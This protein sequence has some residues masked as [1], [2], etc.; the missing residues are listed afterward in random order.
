M[1]N[2]FVHL[3]VHTQYS[4]LD[5]AGRVS[6]LI[7]TAKEKNMS[8]LAI[9]DHGVMYGVVDFYKEAKDQ[10]IKPILGC[11]VYVAERTRHDRDY[12]LDNKQYH[13]VLLAENNE[14][15]KNL[16]KLVSLSFLEGFYY[17]PRVDMELLQKYNEGLIA[18]SACLGG[19]LPAYILEGRYDKARE[20]AL[21]YQNIFGKDNFFLELQDHNIPEEKQVNAD[22]IALS[23]EIGAGI[24]ATND[25]HYTKKEDASIHDVLLCIQTGKELE[26]EDRLKFPGEEFYLKSPEEIEEIFGK[27]PEAL[28][29]TVEIANRCEVEIDLG[30]L[31][32]PVFEVPWGYDSNSYLRKLCYEGLKKRYQEITAEIEERLNYELDVIEEMGYSSYF[33]IVWDFV[34]F[35]HENNI[36]VGPGRGS[37]AGSLVAYTLEITNIDPLKY[38]LLFERFLNPARVNMP[39]IDIDFCYEKREKVIDYV[40]EKYGSEHVAQIITF[41][42][43]Q[44]RAA[45]RDVGRVLGY[46]YG[47][48]DKIAKMIPHVIGMTIERA[49]EENKELKELYDK[50]AN[51][52]NMLDLSMSIEGLYRHA[53]THAA[54]IVI[55]KEPLTEYVPLQ[56][57]NGQVVTQFPMGTLEE[58]GLLKMDFLGLKTLT[59]LNNAVNIISNISGTHIDLNEISFEDEKTFELLKEGNTLGIFQLESS[60]MRNV[61]KE[62]KPT[63]FEDIIAASALFRPGPME[64]I[65]NF[66]KSKHGKQ[67]IE[68]PHP[69][70][71]PILEETYGI[72]VYQEQIMQVANVMAGFS[73]GEADLLRRA[74]GKKKKEILAEQRVKF[75]EGCVQNGYDRELGEKIYE[76]IVKFADYG[77]NK[78]HSAAYACLAYQSAYLK[79][80]YP[81]E[82]MAALLTNSMDNS[83]KISL[84]IEDLKEQG[85]EILP[86]NINESLVNFTVVETGKIRFGLAAVKNVGRA[87]VEEIIKIRKEGGSFKSFLDFAN[88]VNLRVC[89]RKA[90]ESLIKVGAFDNFDVNRKQLLSVLDE[91]L[92][93]ASV[94]NREREKGQLS[95]WDLVEE[96]APGIEVEYPKLDEFTLKER[97]SMEREL[98]G[99][100]V[101]GHPLE[102]YREKINELSLP[103]I[104]TLEQ[105][106]DNALLSVCGIK[107]SINVITTKRGEFM[108]FLTLEDMTGTVEVVVFPP[109]YEA[110]KEFI[111]DDQPLFVKGTLDKKEDEEMKLICKDIR[112][113]EDVDINYA[114]KKNIE[115]SN[116][117]EE[118]KVIYIKVESEKYPYMNKLKNLLK[119]EK[120]ELPVYIYL[121]E[122]KKVKKVGTNYWASVNPSFI[123][124]IKK[125][126]GA[127]AIKIK[128]LNK[129]T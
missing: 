26:D 28:N 61:L 98:L 34:R 57:N 93:Q 89:N 16:M 46:S 126:L 110:S 73:L 36:L 84:Y 106:H 115:D 14:G 3:H 41:G 30:S 12:E 39:D 40:I 124:S 82:F 58:L 29:N 72:M 32:L 86:P 116:E 69:R 66:I 78:S 22:L 44:A 94:L 117:A 38:G 71:K 123:N 120:S 105:Y 129:K 2:N 5:G 1:M 122:E 125:I 95:M 42:T 55:S 91:V 31:H 68:Y 24:V 101:S 51:V 60:G 107:N 80:H 4:L 75:V 23:Q 7:K 10:G 59:M 15:Y 119:E 47:E 108:S 81:T 49:L 35:A 11:E 54:G 121:P 27:H 74:I 48:V 76:L 56:K 13:L 33:L 88:R 118:E 90:M 104:S 50:D 87:A 65:P 83:D 37:A 6:E 9:T 8:A 100:Y 99:F 67:K 128:Y 70:L 111:N 18:L 92:H 21:E 127:D 112:L 102:D 17:K 25:V 64:Q 45:L 85:L 52:K 109:E 114:K 96:E 53:S 62:M 113:L 97:L 77:F 63:S 19:E 20:K 79:A 103:Y 43:M